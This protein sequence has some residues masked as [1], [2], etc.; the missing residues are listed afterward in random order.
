MIF[1]SISIF[2]IVGLGLNF[3]LLARTYARVQEDT[4]FLEE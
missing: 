2:T 4:F 3:H 1:P